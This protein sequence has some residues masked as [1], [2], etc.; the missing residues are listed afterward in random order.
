V[1]HTYRFKAKYDYE[2]NGST[3]VNKYHEY[4]ENIWF[5][6]NPFGSYTL[7]TEYN[8]NEIEPYYGLSMM[9]PPTPYE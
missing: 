2:S 4:I 8:P 5:A 6:D 7:V 1:D 3:N 9:T